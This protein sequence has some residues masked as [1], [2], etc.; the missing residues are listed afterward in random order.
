MDLSDGLA[1]DL[2][3]LAAA[4]G[5]AAAVA[6]ERLPLSAALREYASLAEARELALSGGDDYELLLCVAPQRYQSLAA[7]AEAL[8]LPLCVIG[9][10]H[11]GSGVAWSLDGAPAAPARQGFDHFR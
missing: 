9:E 6:I 2:P 8:G 3:R 4:S 7:A 5:L 1:G 11:A 10:M